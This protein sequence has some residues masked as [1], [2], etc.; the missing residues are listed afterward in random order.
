M[1]PTR[2]AHAVTGQGDTVSADR[3]TH[4]ETGKSWF[5]V[6]IEVDAQALDE[7]RLQLQSGMA[8]VTSQPVTAPEYLAKP[9]GEL[10]TQ[11]A[12][13]EPA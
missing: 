9:F 3:V 2:A 12:L 8:E 7:R 10:F 13:R 6:T 1:I 4:P 5:D 11:R